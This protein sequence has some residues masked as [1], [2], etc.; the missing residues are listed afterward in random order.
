MTRARNCQIDLA[1][2]ASYHIINRCIKRSFLCGK[3]SYS[4]KNYE[5][6]RQWLVDRIKHLATIYSI[7]ITAYAIMSNITL[8]P[9]TACR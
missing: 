6:R 1:A 9:G 2:T 4:G 5:H 3:D 7:D 8:S